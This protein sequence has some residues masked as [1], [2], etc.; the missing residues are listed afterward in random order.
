[1][2]TFVGFGI[3][4]VIAA[5]NSIC[6]AEKPSPIKPRL[7]IGGQEGGPVEAVAFSPDSKLIASSTSEFVH[8]WDAKTGKRIHSFELRNGAIHSL[9]FLPDGKSLLSSTGGGTLKRWDLTE[10]AEH[11]NVLLN[12]SGS[13][14]FALS[15]DGTA[16]SANYSE[17]LQTAGDSLVL[18]DLTT[19]KAKAELEPS[20]K[21]R[22]RQFSPDGKT[23]ATGYYDG[24]IKFWDVATG[25]VRDSARPWDETTIE[26]IN[27]SPNGRL[28][29]VE[30]SSPPRI[31]VWDIEKK[32]EGAVKSDDDR[33][34]EPTFSPDGRQLAV[35]KRGRAR[36]RGIELWD[37][38]TGKVEYLLEN[39]MLPAMKRMAFSPDGK[40]VAVG[41]MTTGPLISNGKVLIWDLP[42]E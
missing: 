7:I 26:R 10:K 31:R 38:A 15:P 28:I 23:L 33:Y 36:H 37:A 6:A 42:P 21:S 17:E 8:V 22:S 2:K 32:V 11:K 16:V 9:A 1:M 19:G 29:A 27:Y 18:W 30:I 40:S 41:T 14:G 12:A 5:L 24:T 39:A 3:L 34:D 13:I 4:I 35:I 25:R 20:T